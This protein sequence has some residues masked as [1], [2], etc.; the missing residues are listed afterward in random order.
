MIM[1]QCYESISGPNPG[2]KSLFLGYQGH[3]SLFLGCPWRPNFTSRVGK[4]R[5]C[6]RLTYGMVSLIVPWDGT[7]K[8]KNN[9]LS[10]DNSCSAIVYEY[11]DEYMMSTSLPMINSELI[12]AKWCWTVNN[13]QSNNSESA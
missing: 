7:H 11:Y 5:L 9:W 10:W 12:R 6:S 1:Y 2:H 8:F 4:W 13:I 3:K